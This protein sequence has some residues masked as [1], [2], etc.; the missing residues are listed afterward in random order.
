MLH[1]SAVLAM[2]HSSYLVVVRRS[3][4]LVFSSL[5]P[6]ATPLLAATGRITRGAEWVGS[7]GRKR[8]ATAVRS[9]LFTRAGQDRL[10][11]HL[12]RKGRATY[13]ELEASRLVSCLAVNSGQHVVAC[14]HVLPLAVG[15]AS[16]NPKHRLCVCVRELLHIYMAHVVP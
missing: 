7:V 14:A 8:V 12:H 2:L 5:A 6:G 11:R 3:H 9:P 15:C 13:L 4:S 10:E 16:R 1:G